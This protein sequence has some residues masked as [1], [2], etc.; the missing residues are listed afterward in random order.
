MGKHLK[1]RKGAAAKKTSLVGQMGLSFFN[2]NPISDTFLVAKESRS[3]DLHLR[4][5]RLEK[6]IFLDKVYFDSL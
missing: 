6:R 5:Q 3:S 4:F 2:C 1:L